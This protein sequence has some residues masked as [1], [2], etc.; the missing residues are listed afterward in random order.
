VKLQR[1]VL[2]E[3]LDVLPVG[4]PVARRSRRDLQRV[5][6]VLRSLT[7][8]RRAVGALSITC[9][10]RRILELGAGDGSLML[11]FALSLRPAWRDV[12]VTFVDRQ[13]LIGP[14]IREPL[15]LLGWDVQVLRMDALDWARASFN[16]QY[17]LCVTT[18]FLHHFQSP[19]LEQLLRAVAAR[20]RAFV[21]CEPRRNRS[22]WI[23]SHLLALLGANEVTREDGVTSVV[24]GF[25]GHE[26]TALWPPS[27]KNWRLREYFAWPFTH[28]LVADEH[29]GAEVGLAR[30][31][32]M[33]PPHGRSLTE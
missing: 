22:A 12:E 6:R 24:A 2:P 27:G 8:L 30:Q 13:D 5:H 26:L 3:H 21:A 20:C 19:A 4:D 28:C 23:G 14:E 1:Q 10:P 16:Q 31:G 9:Q 7:I 18:L 32:H 17:D 11:R 15:G 33:A 29:G 25:A